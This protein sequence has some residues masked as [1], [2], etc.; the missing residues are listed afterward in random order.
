[1]EIA[2]SSG[3]MAGGMLMA[4]WGGFRN[5]VHSMA[6]S[7]FV[8]GLCTLGF[9]LSPVFWVYLAFMALCGVAMPVFNTPATVMLQQKVDGNYLGRVFA[10]VNMLASITMPAGMLV[11][12]PMADVV[13]IERLLLVGAAV[14]LGQSLFMLRNRVLLEAGRQQPRPRP[15]PQQ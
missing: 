6:L 3:M 7:D 10:V 2:W 14:M 1:M 12:G 11:F 15:E 5:R 8:V 9:A 4:V 13:R